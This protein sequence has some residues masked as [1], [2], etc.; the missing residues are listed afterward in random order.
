MSASYR[1]LVGSVSA[2][3]R[4][5]LVQCQRRIGLLEA[6]DGM[7]G[8]G[9]G[10]VCVMH[11]AMLASFSPR[12]TGFVS[13]LCVLRVGADRSCIGLVSAYRLCVCIFWSLPRAYRPSVGGPV[14]GCVCPV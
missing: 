12:D 9:I 11:G 10:S 2:F 8:P 13:A 6:S 1:S 5:L 3:S 14:A 7:A 4:P